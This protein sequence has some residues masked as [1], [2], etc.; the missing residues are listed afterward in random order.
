VL[1]EQ[2]AEQLISGATGLP[3]KAIIKNKSNNGIDMIAIDEKN[4][5]IWVIEVKS[6]QNDNFPKAESLNLVD[7]TKKWINDADMGVINNQPI[8]AEAQEYAAKVKNLMSK[9]Y[10]PKPLYST[11]TVPKPNETRLSTV[12]I[13]AIVD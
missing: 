7:R 5:T 10:K 2:V 4:K 9:G 11:V 8:S 6:S 13:Q 12:T 1:G 3:F